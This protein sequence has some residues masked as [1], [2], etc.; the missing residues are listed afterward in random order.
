[1]K[2]ILEQLSFGHFEK[3]PDSRGDIVSM[4]I[5]RAAARGPASDDESLER[6]KGRLFTVNL[7]GVVAKARESGV[8]LNTITSPKWSGQSIG[9]IEK[10]DIYS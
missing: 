5:G 3:Q 2:W 8:A 6:A 10:E 4:T 1:L 9:A 7:N